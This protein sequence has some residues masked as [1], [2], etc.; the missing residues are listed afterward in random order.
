MKIF[1]ENPNLDEVYQT[2]DENLFFLRNAAENHAKT[3]ADKRV[4]RIVRPDAKGV[5]VIDVDAPNVIGL[6]TFQTGADE[7]GNP[8]LKQAVMVVDEK[9]NGTL[10]SVDVK[11]PQTPE[12]GLVQPLQENIP[13]TDVVEVTV[14]THE[15]TTNLMPQNVNS[16]VVDASVNTATVNDAV[17]PAEP[18]KTTVKPAK[19]TAK[20]TTK[21][22][23]K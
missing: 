6:D 17:K 21:T 5:A 18:A 14:K 7:N 2:A 3:L 1:D 8:N 16:A 23:S 15:G 22:T 13:A 10:D 12:G 4:K 19:T 20:P 11:N 9:G